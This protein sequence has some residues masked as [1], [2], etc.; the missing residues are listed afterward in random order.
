MAENADTREALPAAEIFAVDAAHR[1]AASIAVRRGNLRRIVQ[2]VYTRDLVTPLDMLVRTRLLD[3]IAAARPGAL[4]AD[5]S[6]TLGARPTRD[7]LVFVVHP[8]S[9]DLTLPGGIV[10][11]SRQ[12]VGSLPSDLQLPHGL[13]QSSEARAAL[14]NV[15]ESRS[16]GGRTARTLSRREL[17]LWLDR[18]VS[19]RGDDWARQL[20]DQIGDLAP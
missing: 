6:A 14:E 13:H 2:G 5:R 10:V 16:R 15:V 1:A 9:A 18:Q 17:E 4:I 11:R 20:R 7:N 8:K 12:G 3:V 19:R